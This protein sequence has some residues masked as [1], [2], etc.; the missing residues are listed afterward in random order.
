M[1][2]NPSE[3]VHILTLYEWHPLEL[4]SIQSVQLYMA[5]LAAT[6][7]FLCLLRGSEKLRNDIPAPVF[8]PSLRANQACSCVHEG[9]I[10]PTWS[11]LGP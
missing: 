1:C 7:F 4:Y 2:Y 11:P 10:P 9:S 6:L 5:A 3:Q 8:L